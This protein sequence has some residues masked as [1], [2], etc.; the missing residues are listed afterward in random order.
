M[1][2]PTCHDASTPPLSTSDDA[3]RVCLVAPV[4][5]PCRD[6]T[7]LD[8]L[9]P[10]RSSSPPVLPPTD[11]LRLSVGATNNA[12]C[13]AILACNSVLPP[14]P[15]VPPLSVVAATHGRRGDGGQGGGRHLM[16]ERT[17]FGRH[18]ASERR[19][20]GHNLGRVLSCNGRRPPPCP[21]CPRRTW[22]AATTESDG[23]T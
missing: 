5:G 16:Q 1:S 11:S 6:G 15:V 13:V 19:E 14:L 7:S 21:P 2:N 9:V 23:T 18:A 8:Q 10:S 3:R 12:R 22:V 17:W 20:G 4:R